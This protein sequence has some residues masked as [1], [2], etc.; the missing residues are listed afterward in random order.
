MSKCIVEW[1]DKETKVREYCG[2]HYTQIT[3]HGE[4]KR[5]RGDKNEYIVKGDY[6]EIVLYDKDYNEKCRAIIDLDDMER[7]KPYKWVFR[8]DGYVSAKI[9]GKG[10][11]LHRFIANIPKG[12]HTDHI[13]RNRLDNRKVNLKVCTQSEN[14]KNKSSYSNNKSG[15]RGVEIRENGIY[16]VEIKYDGNRYYLGCYTNFDEAVRVREEYELKFHGKVLEDM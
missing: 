10:I 6:V 15:R 4:I 5:S 16:Y 2:R 9:N 11:K 13:N 12:L 3:R 14:N 7:C 1:C 8:N